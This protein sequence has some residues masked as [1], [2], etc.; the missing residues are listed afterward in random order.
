MQKLDTLQKAE[1]FSKLQA[2]GSVTQ[3]NIRELPEGEVG[4]DIH[5]I[6]FEPTGDHRE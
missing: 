4:C 5:W 6:R 3:Y 2:K 1:I